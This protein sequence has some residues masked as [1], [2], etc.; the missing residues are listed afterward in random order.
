LPARV[1][2]VP[3]LVEVDD[4]RRV[5]RG[6]GLA[7]PRFAIDLGPYRPPGDRLG[8]E[9]VIDPHAEVLVEV[10]G[11]IV[12]PRVA[13]RLGPAQTV[14]VDQAPA[15]ELGERAAL[16]LGNVRAPMA[17]RGVPDIRVR[18]GDVV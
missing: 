8:D 12:P 18:R 1:E 7:L 14:D 2:R 3:R 16:G 6:Q 5:I 11:T 9:Q 17:G 10:A 4:E 15:A 13:P